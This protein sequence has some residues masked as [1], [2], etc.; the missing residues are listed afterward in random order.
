MGCTVRLSVRALAPLICDFRSGMMSLANTRYKC[1]Q[2][3]FS[4]LNTN[5]TENDE[6]KHYYIKAFVLPATN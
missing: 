5:F 3:P 6:G 1:L 2:L 4:T